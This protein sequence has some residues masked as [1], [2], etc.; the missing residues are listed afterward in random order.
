MKKSELK[1]IIKEEIEKVLSESSLSQFGKVLYGSFNDKTPKLSYPLKDITDL[2]TFYKYNF[3]SNLKWPGS[4][5]S[6]VRNA[7][8]FSNIAKETY[9]DMGDD[10]KTY[11]STDSTRA[12]KFINK[13]IEN[14]NM[15]KFTDPETTFNQIATIASRYIK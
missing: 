9:G 11:R 3:Q 8:E 14:M 12:A 13:T 2:Y 7:S 10:Y 4:N 5:L 15:G 1:Q 6:K